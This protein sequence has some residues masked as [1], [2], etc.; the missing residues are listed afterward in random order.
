MNPYAA[1]REMSFSSRGV[2]SRSSLGYLCSQPM[3]IVLPIQAS[4]TRPRS[5]AARQVKQI[6]TTVSPS[7]SGKHLL[8]TNKPVI[9]ERISVGNRLLPVDVVQ[10]SWLLLHIANRACCYLHA[11][12][13]VEGFQKGLYRID[14]T[15]CRYRV[16]PVATCRG[17]LFRLKMPLP[18]PGPIDIVLPLAAQAT[19][20]TSSQDGPSARPDIVPDSPSFLGR[21]LLLFIYCQSSCSGCSRCSRRRISYLR[22]D[23]SSSCLAFLAC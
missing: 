13:V 5:K 17:R 15:L 1:L 3:S 8:H 18:L 23:E 21:P 11:V 6:G 7:P 14:L 4:G 12:F 2:R 20:R 10:V 22:T 19:P 16:A 9:V